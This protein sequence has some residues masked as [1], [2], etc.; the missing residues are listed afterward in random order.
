MCNSKGNVTVCKNRGG[1]GK[2][3]YNLGM[4]TT[5]MNPVHVALIEAD[6]LAVHD[7]T[8]KRITQTLQD[9]YMVYVDRMVMYYV[10]R[11]DKIIDVIVD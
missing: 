10:I 6:L 7:K 3:M 1:T 2:L 5:E 4:D 8:A 11:D 9:T